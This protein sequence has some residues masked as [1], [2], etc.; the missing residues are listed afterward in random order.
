MD[1]STL[2]LELCQFKA[3]EVKVIVNIN[4]QIFELDISDVVYDKDSKSYKL[5]TSE[6]K[7]VKI[8]T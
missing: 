4:N 1:K 6:V 2:I 8:E 5:I 7:S 3:D